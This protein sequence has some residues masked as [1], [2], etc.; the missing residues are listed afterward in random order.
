MK[1]VPD[2]MRSTIEDTI[3]R[4]NENHCRYAGFTS[5]GSEREERDVVLKEAIS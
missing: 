5:T 2:K 3:R 1:K 4:G